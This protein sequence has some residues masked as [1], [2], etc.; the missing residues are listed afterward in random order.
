M[1]GGRGIG[2]LKLP[3]P[4]LLAALLTG[5]L[6]LA[7]LFLQPVIGMADNG[8][9]YRIM[10]G[11]GLYKLDRYEAGQ[12]FSNFSTQYGMYQYYNEFASGF[13]SAQ[14]PLIRLAILLDKLFTG[15]DGIFDIRF[16]AVILSIYCMAAVYLF[17]KYATL[18]AKGPLAYLIA[19]MAVFIFADVGYVAYF[20]S[21]YAEG[22]AFVSFLAAIACA[23]LI[24]AGWGKKDLLLIAFTVNSLILTCSKQQFAP[25]GVLLGLLCLLLNTPHKGLSR[26]NGLKWLK[27]GCAALLAAA[28]VL[29]YILI[30]QEFVDINAYHAMTRGILMTSEDPEKALKDFGINPQYALL[31]Q[32]IY[33]EQNPVIDVQDSMLK[34]DFYAKYGFTSIAKYYALHPGQLI[35][36]LNEAA[37]SA[38]SIRPESI[39][40]Y[41]K[42]AGY[43]PGAQASFF[44]LYSTVKKAWVPKT[45]GF[46]ML[47]FAGMLA[48]SFKDRQRMLVLMFVLVM[49]LSQIAVSIIGAGD[50]DLAKHMF[51][52]NAAFDISVFVLLSAAISRFSVLRYKAA[53]KKA[54]LVLEQAVAA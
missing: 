30:P 33:Y 20:N 29:V 25:L 19:L 48:V 37:R 45:I 17:T 54:A 15:Q 23:L 28:G 36:M 11:N 51:L 3:S 43:A 31:D 39:G 44:S 35:S 53:E 1:K 8:D 34:E 10:V 4:P 47:F 13:Q 41:E 32:S 21:F 26:Q 22:L 52:Y 14:T 42:N 40:N 38:N 12:Y 24:S 50:A 2:R 9:F 7:M 18:R 16:Q 49:G 5:I 27:R 6:L 46:I